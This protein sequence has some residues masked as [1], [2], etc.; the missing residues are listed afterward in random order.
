MRKCGIKGH[1]DENKI[2]NQ[3]PAEGV[4]QDIRKKWY[5]EIFCTY[6]PRG[7]WCYGYTYLEKIMQI[8][9]STAGKLQVRTP[10]E[11]LTGETP[12]ISKYLDFGWYDIFWYKEDIV[13]GETKIGRFLVPSQKVGSLMSY[14]VF[15]KSGIPISRTTLKRVTH[16]ETQTDANRKRFEHYDTA[17]TERFHEVYTQESFSAPSSDKPTM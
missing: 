5:R 4:I 7:I 14:W 15:P 13:L 16:L 1:T 17:I 10:L 12:D 8:T 11:M 6:S 9:A 2:S 3:N